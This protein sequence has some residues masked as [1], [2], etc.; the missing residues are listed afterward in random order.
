MQPTLVEI[1]SAAAADI[2]DS[3]SADLLDEINRKQRMFRLWP[4][5]STAV[6]I[7]V[8]V[9]MAHWPA[10]G[11]VTMAILGAIGIFIAYQRDAL[12]K[13]VVLFY[14]L[15]PALSQ[16]YDALHQWALQMASC[17]RVWHVEAQGR[18]ADRKYHAGASYVVRRN[19]TKIRRAQPPYVKT[20]IDTIAIGVGT[21][22]LH[23]FPDRL[24]IVDSR[25]V[26]AISYSGLQLRTAP[27][28]FIEDGTV[29]SDASVVG[30]TWKYVNKK[31]GADKRFKDNRE[32]PVCLYDELSIQSSSGLDERLQLS[33]TNVAQ[34]F[35]HAVRQLSAHLPPN[36][37]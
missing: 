36:H 29:P 2:V 22:T 5:V 37:Y 35:V 24:L 15:D 32:L 30:R 1:D 6:L 33:R 13:T 14:D 12:A 10:W 26:G 27:S 34:G 17:A 21:Q 3:S 7:A 8:L 20:N 18:V 4:I 23:F 31:G 16:A 25:G 28:Q 11:V 19:L 9:A